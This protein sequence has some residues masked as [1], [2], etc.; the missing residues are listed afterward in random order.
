MTPA[1]AMSLAEAICR[2]RGWHPTLAVYVVEGLRVQAETAEAEC[3]EFRKDAE[4]YRWLRDVGDNTWEPFC[5]RPHPFDYNV[6]AAIDAA[7]ER[8]DKKR[9]AMITALSAKGKD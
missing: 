9:V 8:G 1:E 6:D 3:A 2:K 5:K 7:I 4:R